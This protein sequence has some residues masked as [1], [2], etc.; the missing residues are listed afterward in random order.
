MV[1]VLGYNTAPVA[2][3]VPTNYIFEKLEDQILIPSNTPCRFEHF[4]QIQV[5]GIRSELEHLLGKCCPLGFL[6]VCFFV[7]FFLCRLICLRSFPVWC[8]GYDAEFDCISF[9]SLPFIYFALNTIYVS[10]WPHIMNY[11]D[12]TKCLP[13]YKHVYFCL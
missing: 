13:R 4:K 12:K 9:G 3:T 6:L 8:L 10:I 5:F 2:S 11:V 1:V 7:L